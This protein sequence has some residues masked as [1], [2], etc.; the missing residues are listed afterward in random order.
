MCADK[1]LKKELETSSVKNNNELDS[2]VVGI[3]A[4]AGGLE[5]L[6]KF[7]LLAQ[8]TPAW[9]LLWFSIYRQITKA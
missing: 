1:S 8:M 5:A 7:F 9:R 3:G 6:E 2:Y 4:S